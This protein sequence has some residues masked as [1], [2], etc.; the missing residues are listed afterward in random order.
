M[1]HSILLHVMKS[2]PVTRDRMIVS[3]DDDDDDDDD[4]AVI[5]AYIYI[6][7]CIVYVFS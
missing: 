3:P 7:T 5:I 6:Y 1:K 2:I 4:D